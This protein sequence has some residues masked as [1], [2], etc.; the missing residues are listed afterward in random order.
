[1]PNLPHSLPTTGAGSSAPISTPAVQS[2][3]PQLP[4]GFEV[5]QGQTDP[6]VQFLSRGSGY[7]LFLSG[8]AAT[9][10]LS[11]PQEVTNTGASAASVASGLQPGTTDLTVGDATTTA[12]QMQ[13]VGAN[14]AARAVGVDQEPG[15]V[16]YLIGNDPSQWH[17]DIATYA[18]VEYQNLYPGIN[19]VYY[20]NQGQLEYDWQLAPGADPGL[21]RLAFPGSDQVALDHQG[22]LIV[23]QGGA[24]VTEQAPVLYQEIGGGRQ[25]VSGHFVWETGGQV[26][27]TVGAYDHSQP[28]V[29]DPA[30]SFS[31]YLGG[32]GSDM[33][34]GIAAAAGNVYVTGIATSLNFPTRNAF[35]STRTSPIDT[36]VSAFDPNGN[37]VY[38]TYL[39]G[40]G[41]QEG[42]AIA[43]DASGSAY[44]TGFT[45]STNFP[46]TPGAYQTT[47]AGGYDTFV[48]K[49]TPAGNALAY[50]T[51]LG[52]SGSDQGF[53]IA[54][55]AAGN[56]TVAGT[57][58]STNFP[59]AQPLQSTLKGSSAA[60]VTRLNATGSGL[61]Y[62]T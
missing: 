60:F 22:D 13:F 48:T 6:Q 24:T 12:L 34:K 19:L 3:V 58:S 41:I 16:N 62:S 1:M 46:T 32:S 5:N 21:I 31:T 17:T 11:V 50:S 51:S 14:P 36:F 45:S 43:A 47:S 42:A 44:V 33:A 35:Q 29:I 8:G 26:G 4:L 25:A 9:F 23:R 28:L 53:G 49:L 15:V 18:K 27:L 59:T 20:G 37:L 57:T 56:A 54:V 40:S 10:A 52:G 2:A 38:S 39:G 7:N 55:D 61:G 30:L